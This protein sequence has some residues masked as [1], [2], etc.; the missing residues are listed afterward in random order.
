MAYP[1]LYKDEL[2]ILETQNI[3]VKSVSFNA[4]LTNRRLI[5]IDSK[6]Q[7]LPPQEILLATLKNVDSGENAIRDPTLTISI[8]TNTGTT[9]QMI[10][11]FSKTSGGER[12]RECDEWV[13]ALRQQISHT[14]EH[15]PILPDLPAPAEEEPVHENIPPAAS[16]P[17]IEIVNAPPQKKRIE[18][19][20]PMKKIIES[21]PAMPKPVETSSLPEG[22][23]CN[24]CGSRVPAESAFCNR[25]GTPVVKDSDLEATFRK[26]YPQS[27]SAQEA[28]APAVPQV[29]VP[30]PPQ[31][32][33]AANK[34]ERPIEQVI[35]SIEPLI[36]S[37]YAITEPEPSLAKITEPAGQATGS[38]CNRCGN[39]L[40]DGSTFCNRCGTPVVVDSNQEPPVQQFNQPV[41]TPESSVSAVPQVAVP[42]PPAFG[43]AADKK[44]RPLEQ[45]I[46]SIEPL[47]EGSVPRTEP[48]PLIPR[49]A[50]YQP[51]EPAIVPTESPAQTGEVKWPVISPSMDFSVSASTAPETPPQPSEGSSGRGKKVA[52]AVL[53]IVILA[54]IAGIFIFANP[55][56][57]INGNT[58][59]ATPAPTIIPVG[60]P[61]IEETTLP[62]ETPI[63]ETPPP[64]PELTLPP[65]TAIASAIPP[66]GVWVTVSYPNKFTGTIGTPNALRDVSD[67]GNK[68]YQVSTS[69]GTVTASIQKVDGSGDELTVAIYKDGVL[70]AK[71]STTAPKGLIEIQESLKP[72]PT[73]TVVPITVLITPTPIDTTL[74]GNATANTTADIPASG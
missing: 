50:S 21:A 54:V 46:H 32:G 61:L 67:T 2:K 49:P 4:V 59:I 25:C 41:P 55:L 47:I 3:K 35:H 72:A 19:S 38:F 56:Q 42:I 20:R 33:L 26:Q 14:I 5:L 18:I 53:A 43:L 51:P 73:P 63:P 52:I 17:R 65:A 23:F 8:I 39:R 74:A 60:T 44:E 66:T 1:D 37:P 48:A 69:I 36:D 16:T 6:K 9:R 62:V 22:S 40:P 34:K 71:K 45:V 29:A 57:M 13:R 11:T 10:L 68:F 12:K 27:P 58:T 28:P 64:T 24:R 31:F 15:H 30:L 70:V 7:M